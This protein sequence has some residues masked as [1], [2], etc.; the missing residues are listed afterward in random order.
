MKSPEKLTYTNMSAEN[1][2]RKQEFSDKLRSSIEES[3]ARAEEQQKREA[4][5]KRFE[6]ARAGLRDLEARR[7]PDAIKNFLSYLKILE[8]WKKVRRNELIPAIFDIKAEAGEIAL[9]CAIYWE[10]AKI[11][12][13]T[14]TKRGSEDLRVYLGKFVAF[15]KNSPFA[16]V[17]SETL[18]KYIARDKPRHRKEFNDAYVKLAG[19][20]CFIAHALEEDLSNETI[21]GLR[22]FRDRFLAESWWGEKLI[23]I[24]YQIG[25]KIAESPH[26]QNPVL[27]AILVPALNWV[28]TLSARHYRSEMDGK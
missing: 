7:F 5:V 12:D 8:D 22:I 11:F 20:Q 23:G 18:R 25:P 1:A 17:C 10:L 13:S 21:P 27:K 4:W 15:S 3:I 16:A 19:K 24:Y 9:L 14:K 26:L 6:H 2:D 28:A